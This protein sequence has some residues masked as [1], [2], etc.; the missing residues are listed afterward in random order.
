MSSLI[1]ERAL[2]KQHSKQQQK[3]LSAM[4][5]SPSFVSELML[6]RKAKYSNHALMRNLGEFTAGQCPQGGV[7]LLLLCSLVVSELLWGLNAGQCYTTG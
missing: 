1:I 3:L 6:C 2:D 7:W 5:L 4:E